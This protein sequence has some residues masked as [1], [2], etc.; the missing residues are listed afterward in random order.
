MASLYGDLRHLLPDNYKRLITAWLE[1][2][3]PSFDYGGFVVGESEGEARLLGK[4][5]GILAGVPFFDEVFS[6]L[7]CTVTWHIPETT[8]ISPITHIATVRGP[9]RKILLGERVALNILARCSGIATKTSTLVTALRAHGWAGTLAGTRKTTPGF[10]VVEKY[11]IL[12]GGADPHRHDLSAMTMLK[13]NHVWACANNSAAKDGGSAVKVVGEQEGGIVAAIPRA[14]QA[15]KAVGGFATKV[16]VECR[17][18]E[19][20]GAAIEAGA[21]VIML[22]NFT[23]EGV[24]DAARRLKEEWKGKE[25]AFLIEVSGGLNEGNAA[26]YA[27]PDVDILSTSSIHQG[28]GIVDFSLKVSLR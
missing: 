10:R 7:G 24:R 15:A 17:S 20:A 25:K 8:P 9:I 11:G 27:C 6:Q 1:E 28:T 16:E 22:D 18:L 13:D 2:D 4:S 26:L 5:E 21:D 3:C 23:P 19:E 14:V 12:V